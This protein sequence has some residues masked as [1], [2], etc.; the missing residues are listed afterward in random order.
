MK[1]NAPIA[2]K[3]LKYER[4]HFICILIDGKGGFI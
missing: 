4:C 2:V 1:K 3:G